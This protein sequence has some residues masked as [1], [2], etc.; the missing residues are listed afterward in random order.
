MLKDFSIVVDDRPLLTPERVISLR[1][2]D[3][4]GIE[5]DSLDVVF[6][7]F[8][9][10]LSLPRSGA[11]LKVSLGYRGD[12]MEYGSYVADDVTVEQGRISI[13]ATGFNKAKSLKSIKNKRKKTLMFGVILNLYLEKRI[14]KN[15]SE[16]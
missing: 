4:I 1:V 5:S 8:D 16:K 11:I 6:D 14:T 13:A 9:G 2:G 12:L 10:A 7:D 3:R 15:L